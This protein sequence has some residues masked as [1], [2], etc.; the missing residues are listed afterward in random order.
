MERT[1]PLNA[2]GLSHQFM[3]AHIRPGDFCIDAT[4][5]RGRDT[6][7][8][9]S[10]VGETGRVLAMDIQEA[11]VAETRE[12]LAREGCLQRTQAFMYSIKGQL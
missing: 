7:F 5:G 9:C 6:L 3:A 11:A 1:Y 4:A 8:L 10:L 12:L 2:L